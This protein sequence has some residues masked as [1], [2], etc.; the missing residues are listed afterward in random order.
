MK[1]TK[2][3]LSIVCAAIMML[4]ILGTLT[5]CGAKK[6][7][8]LIYT[9]SEDFK[10]EH[11]TKCLNEKFPEYEIVIEYMSTGNH[12]AKLLAEGKSTEC[13]ITH[14][15]DYGYLSQLDAAGVLADLS[16]YDKSVYME[17][18]NLSENYII[19]LRNGG[20]IIVNTDVLKA[21]G[22][23]E[24]TSYADLLKP[25]YKNLISMPNPKASG[26]G[27][28]FLKSL[29]NAWGEEEAYKYFDNLTENVLAYTS[30]G[31]GPV[32]ALIQEEAAIGLGMIAQ[33][34]TEI[35]NGA[36]L[37]ILFFEEGAPYTLYGQS[38]IN[39]KEAREAVKRV[40][41]YLINE[42]NYEN[43]EKFFPEKI[44][45]DKDYVVENYPVN[46][47]YADMSNNTIDEKNR[48]LD[49]WKY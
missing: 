16:S 2:R 42:Y 6:E 40:F 45:K 38:I 22:L 17:D 44:Y 8:V 13:D 36:P 29:V 31:S 14:D 7:K 23:S 48:L 46:I 12:A 47:K 15:M 34:V 11:M 21:K 33:A 37:K 26:T 28:M 35:N 49:K 1:T 27:Y 39:G 9:S 41:D 10:I 19:E 24:P 20:A 18:T 32:K 5:G 3:I 25:E 30:S 43:N 4:S